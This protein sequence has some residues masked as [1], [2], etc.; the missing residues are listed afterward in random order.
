MSDSV[1]SAIKRLAEGADLDAD[2]ARLAL[3]EIMSGQVPE[4]LTAA[5]LMGLRVK[6]ETVDELHGCV[7]AMRAVG[8]AIHPSRR[9]LVD[10]CGTGGD[11]R[12]TF[13][14]STVT[15]FVVAGAGAAVAKHGNRSVSSR[16]GSADVLEA[17]GVQLLQEPE[18]V[19]RCIDELGIGFMFAPY[20][21]PAI[22]SVA[23]V[24]RALGVRTVF[25]LL[26]P[27][28]NPA[29]AEAQLIGVYAPEWVLPVARVAALLGVKSCMVVHGAGGTDELTLAGPSLAARLDHGVVRE[30]EVDPAELGFSHADL[31]ELSGGEPDQN[32][33][34][35][36]AVLQGTD[37]GPHR[38][39]VVLNAAAAL[40]TCGR[41]GNLR[42]GVE[43]ARRSLRSGAAL[44]KL[45]AL[46]RFSGGM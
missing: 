16:S 12:S 25:N 34:L 21:H 40:W 41:A 2:Q 42:E 31:D 28:S 26:G 45:E 19:E 13:N 8:R 18:R 32:A 37:S 1:R 33:A 29:R 10:T 22:G 27:L 14:V 44:E 6:G 24:R 9:P 11:A 30:L 3:S 4:P 20:F 17:L 43:L 35:A 7:Q 15:A 46:R 39:V 36:R 38:E 23:G 5:F